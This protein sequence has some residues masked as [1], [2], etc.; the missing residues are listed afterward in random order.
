MNKPCLSF[1]LALLLAVPGLPAHAEQRT[2]VKSPV[3]GVLCD[4]YVCANDKGISRELTE[5]Y[6]G[7]KAA[8]NKMF[9]SSDLD[10]TEF[11]F[12]NGIFC[13]V[14]ERLCREDR[15]YGAN[16]KRTGAVSEKYTKLL[17]NNGESDRSR[18]AVPS[19]SGADR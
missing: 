14:K 10:L 4:R 15:Y 6:L 17:F 3:P 9:T 7:K 13:D 8:A 12:A 5:K 19:V 16:G 2:A 11:T 18:D 1:S